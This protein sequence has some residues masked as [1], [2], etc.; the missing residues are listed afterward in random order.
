MTDRIPE[1]LQICLYVQGVGE[2]KSTLVITPSIPGD[3]GSFSA[4]G[5]D[6]EGLF[7]ITEDGQKARFGEDF[8]EA[9]YDEP[10]DALLTVL[11][12]D[13]DNV[14]DF[15]YEISRLPRTVVPAFGG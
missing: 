4:V 5:E 14:V 1:E 7:L 3:Y 6:E 11:V 13:D 8:S 15:E 2:D 10:E 9:V 12:M